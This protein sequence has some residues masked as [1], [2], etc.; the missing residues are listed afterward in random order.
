[1]AKQ[2]NFTKEYEKEAHRL[3]QT[4]CRTQ[5]E[6]AQDLGVGLSTLV[7]KANELAGK[8]R[9]SLGEAVGNDE[10]RAKG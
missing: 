2:K 8:A 5:R 1:M 6:I 7:R 4:S 9:Q 10:I 3:A